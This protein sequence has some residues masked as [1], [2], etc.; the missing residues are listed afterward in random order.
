MVLNALT[1]SP[2]EP[3]DMASIEF[4]LLTFKT[5][6]L[7]ALASGARRGEIHALGQSHIRWS[8]DGKDIFLRLY[9]G[10]MAKTRM[11]QDPS[12]TLTVVFLSSH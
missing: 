3:H 9:V 4:K 5:V 12:T 8:S 7:L 10:V 1:K 6:F 11:T 2:F